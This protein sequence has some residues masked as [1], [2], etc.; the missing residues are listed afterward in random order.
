MLSVQN[1][2]KHDGFMHTQ[3]QK[4]KI[5]FN[6]KDRIT[7]GHIIFFYLFC[8]KERAVFFN[9]SLRGITPFERVT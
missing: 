4:N 2:I 7:A 9:L 6:S 8:N 1:S 5:I 3:K